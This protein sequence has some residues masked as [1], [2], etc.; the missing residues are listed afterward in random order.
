MS[1]LTVNRVLDNSKIFAE[2][3]VV[4]YNLSEQFSH[5]KLPLYMLFPLLF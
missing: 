5:E 1:A 4:N 3:I 2:M